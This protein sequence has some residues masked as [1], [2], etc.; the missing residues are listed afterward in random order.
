MV[1]ALVAELDDAVKV[2]KGFLLC[3]L[4]FTELFDEVLL[5]A[6]QLLHLGGDIV[7]RLLADLLALCIQPGCFLLLLG[8]RQGLILDELSLMELYLLRALSL[9]VDVELLLIEALLI[10]L[11]LLLHHQLLR[12]LVHSVDVRIVSA[13][14]L[15]RELLHSY[16]PQPS[17][18]L[19]LLPYRVQM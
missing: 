17:V 14:L 9:A 7:D 5:H 2:F 12:L 11:P 3:V 1:D 18:L 8:L 10:A 15:Y 4:C 6:L 16:I 13:L 19:L